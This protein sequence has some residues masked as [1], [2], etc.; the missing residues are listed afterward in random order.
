MNDARERRRTA[1]PLV[2]V[3]I[4][5]HN[6]S[7]VLAATLRA[8]IDVLAGQ[9]AR[10]EIVV[11]DDGS[12]DATWAVLARAAAGNPAIRGLRLSRHFG[13][14]AALCAG[15]DAASGDIVV[16]MDGDL[17]HPPPLIPA[18]LKMW[19]EGADIVDAVKTTTAAGTIEGLRSRLFYALLRLLARR[20]LEGMSDFKLLDRSVLDA[21]RRMPERNV[22]Y[23]GMTD[24]LGFRRVEI[25]FEVPP[26][27]AGRT[28]F[29]LW[30]LIRLALTAVTS[31]SSAPLHAIT[32]IGVAFLIFA[33]A[34]G[35]QTLWRKFTGTALDGFTTVILLLLITGSAI[36]IGLGVIGVYIARIYDEVKA[37]PRYVVAEAC[38]DDRG[39]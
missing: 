18:M 8:V 10:S 30:A 4:P 17:Q 38:G 35:A 37:R 13:K 7:A 33:G 20:D 5:V 23:R 12:T 19:S 36:M 21:Y 34:L 15:L 11:V 29:T 26:R 14:E 24:W 28:R 31:F 27:P 6:E 25:G 2:S 39:R 3:I 9:S 1:D 32:T 22:F 16:T